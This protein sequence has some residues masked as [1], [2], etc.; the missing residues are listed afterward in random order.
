MR[1]PLSKKS[2]YGVGRLLRQA[3]VTTCG[4]LCPA[5]RKISRFCGGD[6]GFVLGCARIGRKEGLDQLRDL[7]LGHVADAGHMLHHDQPAQVAQLIEAFLA[8]DSGAP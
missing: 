6:R 4:R 7:R 3:P 1:H 5:G 8:A 2:D